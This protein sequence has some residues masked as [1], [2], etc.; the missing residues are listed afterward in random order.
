MNQ[1]KE[2]KLA[3]EYQDAGNDFSGEIAQVRAG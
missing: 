2:M 3:Q 1:K